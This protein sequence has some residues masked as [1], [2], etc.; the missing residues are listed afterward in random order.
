MFHLFIL[1][2]ESVFKLLSCL[3]SDAESFPGLVAKFNE[4]RHDGTRRTEKTKCADCPG[5][6]QDLDHGTY[7]YLFE[8]K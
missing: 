5:L 8:N 3:V 1:S 2:L 4:Q 7:L 6:V